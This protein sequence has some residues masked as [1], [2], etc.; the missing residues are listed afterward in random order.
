MAGRRG[1]VRGTGRAPC[2]S[3]RRP[4]GARRDARRPAPSRDRSLRVPGAP[5]RALEGPRREGGIR[6]HRVLLGGRHRAARGKRGAPV[7]AAHRARRSQGLGPRAHREGTRRD[8]ERARRARGRGGGPRGG[9]GAGHRRA[10]GLARRRARQMAPRAAGERPQRVSAFRH[11]RRRAPRPRDRPHVRGSR[12]RLDRRLQDEQPRRREPRAL[13]RR[14]GG[15]LS[16]PARALRGRH[17]Q[18]GRAARALFS[19]AERMARMD[20]MRSLAAVAMSLSTLAP[21]QDILKDSPASY[22]RDLDPEYTLYLE[23]PAGRVAI[24]LAASYAPANV[25]AV[26]KLAREKYF[27]AS[28]VTRS[29]DN[30]VVQWARADDDERAKAMAKVKVKV[31]PEFSRAMDAKLPFTR[32]AYP[33][34]YAPEVGFSNGFPVA[35]D[36]K[37]RRTWLVHCYGAVRVGRGH[38]AGSGN[39]SQLYP[40]SGPSPRGLERNITLV[41][42]VVRGMELLSVMPR[43]TGAMGFYEKPSQPIAIREMRLAANLPAGERLDLQALR[44]E[45][46][47]FKAYVESR[48]NRRE[49]W[50]KEPIGRLG[51]CN[52]TLPIREKPR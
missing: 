10:C 21:G 26:R 27:D 50:F 39:G 8:Q 2:T 13:P 19:P 17:G 3:G 44:T 35:R 1:R 9:V 11:G 4:G 5:A 6:R 48:A 36:P 46:A 22:S 41:G 40:V 31:K 14:P 29:Q 33:D 43:G 32:L 7:V 51:V 12:R 24:E 45:S 34:T 52:L 20:V 18:A 28:F 25:E 47:T 30:Y 38:E 16:S 37:T 23:L 15:A 49:E 42:R